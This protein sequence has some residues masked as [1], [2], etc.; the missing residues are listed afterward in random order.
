MLVVLVRR[1]GNG[2]ANDER[3]DSEEDTLCHCRLQELRAG[4][5]KMVRGGGEAHE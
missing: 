4:D 1:Y 2:R 5:E 3:R